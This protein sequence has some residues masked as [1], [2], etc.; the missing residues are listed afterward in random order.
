MATKRIA[1]RN[2]CAYI[3]AMTKQPNHRTN[4]R[5]RWHVSVLSKDGQRLIHHCQCEDEKEVQAICSEA[6]S[7]SLHYQLW[8]R[9]PA[10]VPAY[11]WD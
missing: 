10:D 4:R 1:K 9:P 8:I 11:S 6:R 3:I 7:H 2:Y 5:S